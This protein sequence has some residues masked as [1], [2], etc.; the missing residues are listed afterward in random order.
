MVFIFKYLNN[1]KNLFFNL[2][3]VIPGAGA[4]EI[5]AYCTLKKV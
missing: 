2:G 5:A 3:A 4:F 1:E